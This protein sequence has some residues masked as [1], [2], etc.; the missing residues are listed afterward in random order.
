MKQYD[1]ESRLV[2]LCG[3][4]CRM[5]DYFTGRIRNTARALLGIVRD[6]PELKIFA[7]S[8]HS[9]DYENLL[10]GLEW[11][12]TDVAPCIGGCKGGGGWED[13]PVRR[14]C[15]ERGMQ[16]CYQ[17]SDFPCKAL[18]PVSYTHLTLPTNREV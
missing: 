17:C 1:G 14:C 3:I 18:E 6:H 16:F 9:C 2:G 5:C 13:C 8:S 7:N 11:L 12:S 10:K 15:L 4:Y